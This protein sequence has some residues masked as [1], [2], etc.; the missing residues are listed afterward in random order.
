MVIMQANNDAIFLSQSRE[1]NN[2]YSHLSCP[3]FEA[4]TSAQND[5]SN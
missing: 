5:A 1:D 4:L 3:T 2:V